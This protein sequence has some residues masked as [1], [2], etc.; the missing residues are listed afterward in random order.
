MIQQLSFHKALSSRHISVPK[1]CPEPWL[2]AGPCEVSWCV[3][4]GHDPCFQGPYSRQLDADVMCWMKWGKHT[5]SVLAVWQV[6]EKSAFVQVQGQYLETKNC[7][8]YARIYRNE[9]TERSTGEAFSAE[10][11]KA[12]KWEFAPGWLRHWECLSLLGPL[13]LKQWESSLQG[14]KKESESEVTQSC[15]TLCDP[16]GCSLPDS[17]VHGILQAGIL[18]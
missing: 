1:L 15:L 4:V 18:E 2:C 17:S 8:G 10:E 7:E 6:R 5:W 3:Y 14:L 13:L 12:P 16:M 11:T 9:K